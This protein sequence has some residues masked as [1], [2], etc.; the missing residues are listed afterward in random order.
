M[1]AQELFKISNVL[2]STN[3]SRTLELPIAINCF[4]A[5][6]VVSLFVFCVE[7]TRTEN[8]SVARF[9]VK[10]VTLLFNKQIICAT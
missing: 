4:Y 1:N 5:E 7:E 9:I 6:N 3:S 2:R 10:P 8:T